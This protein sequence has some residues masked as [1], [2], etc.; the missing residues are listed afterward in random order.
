M[1]SQYSASYTSTNQARDGSFRRIE[2]RANNRDLKL[3]VR[4]GYY[5]AKD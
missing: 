4:K 5:A 1:R 3:Q 2:I